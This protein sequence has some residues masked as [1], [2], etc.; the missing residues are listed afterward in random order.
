MR[1]SKGWLIVQNAEEFATAAKALMEN[2]GLFLLDRMTL[3]SL[4]KK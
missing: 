2:W 4:K 1:K 3:K